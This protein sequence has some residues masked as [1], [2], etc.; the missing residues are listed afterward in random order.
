MFDSPR[1][2]DDATLALVVRAQAGDHD[3]MAELCARCTPRVRGLAALRLGSTLVDMNDFDDIVQETMLTAIRKLSGFQPESEG[4]FIAWLASI[5]ESR[6]QDA[7]RSGHAQKRGGG[8]VQRRADLGV[9]TISSL[10]GA[11]PARSPSE[12]AGAVELDG[13]LERAMLGLGSPL[14]D[15]VYHK[16]V[17]ELTHEE[18]AA[19]L[20]LASA[21]SS[22][23]LFSKALARLRERLDDPR[24]D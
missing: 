17:L 9:T 6:I 10:G 7:R 1:P 12:L 4:R 20:G 13:R 15:V 16:L 11:D 2:F 14:G 21:D 8:A 24:E 5:V 19:E 23:A 3:A 18:I 22:R